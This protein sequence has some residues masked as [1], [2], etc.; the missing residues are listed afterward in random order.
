MKRF[1]CVVLSVVLLLSGLSALNFADGVDKPQFIDAKSGEG[2]DD[3]EKLISRVK[4]EDPDKK[5]SINDVYKLVMPQGVYVNVIEK[6]NAQK[7][8]FIDFLQSHG[9]DL[10]SPSVSEEIMKAIQN[11]GNDLQTAMNTVEVNFVNE[12]GKPY[13]ELAKNSPNDSVDENEDKV[14]FS[15]LPIRFN[16]GV[17]VD[18][19]QCKI[20][21]TSI[22]HD[23]DWGYKLNLQLENKSPDKKY[24]FS[25]QSSAINGVEIRSNFVKAIAAGKKANDDIVFSNKHIM[26]AGIQAVTDIELTFKVYD[27]DDWSSDDVVKDTFHVY[28]YGEEYATKYIRKD[29]LSD[30]VLVDET[31][32]KMILLNY[33]KEERSYNVDLFLENKTDKNLMFAARDVSV[34]GFMLNPHFVENVGSNRC[35]YASMDWYNSKLKEN[36]I[37]EVEDIEFI[38]KVYNGDDWSEGYIVDKTI[39]LKP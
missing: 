8:A 20:T 38:I 22:E 28:P 34:N 26:K 18:N 15:K 39:T 10:T 14:D 35:K 30:Q 2:F 27:Y 5:I 31:K 7:K 11:S 16:S 37:D 36:G 32:V 21:I 25:L 1:L 6:Y 23:Y 24:M 12:N 4:T 17:L 9:V 13:S 3:V 29:K 19:N 33:R